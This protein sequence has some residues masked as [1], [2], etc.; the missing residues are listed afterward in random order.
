ML[1]KGVGR[2]LIGGAGFALSVASRQLP[3]GGS[4]WRS[5]G[6]FGEIGGTVKTVPYRLGG[7][8]NTT[9]PPHSGPPPLKRGGWG[10]L[11][12]RKCGIGGTVKT[13]PYRLRKNQS[14][15]G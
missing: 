15:R 5:A 13:V 11:I 8:A 6:D 2:L 9:L 3:R 14:E 10:R 7:C 4:P 1:G 12:G